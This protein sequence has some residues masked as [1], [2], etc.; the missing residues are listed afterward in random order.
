[1]ESLIPSYVEALCNEIIRLGATKEGALTLHTVYFGGGTP[2]LLTAN[3]VEQILLALDASF[4]LQTNSEITLEANPGTLSISQLKGLRNL[5]VNRLSLGMQ[6]ANHYELRL[7]GRI[8]KFE[9]V[10]Q[11]V[12]LSRRAG[13][14]NLNLDL[15]YGLPEQHLESWKSSLR[16]ALDLAPE[17][18]SIY[19][20][21]IEEGTPLDNQIKQGLIPSPD[22]DLAA[23]MYEWAGEQLEQSGYTQYEISNWA[24]KNS[25]KYAC[26]HNLQY[27]RN[28]PY[29]GIGAG[30]H[31]YS[32]NIRT[33]NE[34]SPIL[35]IQRLVETMSNQDPEN[36]TGIP[37]NLD[38]GFPV[39]PATREV[40]AID[41]GEEMGETMM[42]GLRLTEEGVSEKTFYQ[43]FGVSMLEVYQPQIEQL[44]GAGLLEWNS[45]N[46]EVLWL[47]K[48][49][50]LLG[51]RVFME[52]I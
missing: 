35:Y 15:I 30:A 7:L 48:N 18:L 17:H 21:T 5:G 19:C 39:T 1:M 26:L 51:N 33:E 14:D 25:K 44:I 29:L 24:R 3:Q 43:R 42:M 16:L 41:R 8:H 36:Q 4:D 10:T 13:F 11:S 34:N 50:R 6:S 27:W 49:G 31:G 45:G 23:E 37:S 46:R 22:D 12:E 9:E 32:R 40:K 38:K 47:T 52:F 2:S 20:L 28:L